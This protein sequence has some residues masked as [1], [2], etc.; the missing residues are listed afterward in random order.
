M[1]FGYFLSPVVISWRIDIFWNRANLILDPRFT[2][3]RAERPKG[4]I[5]KGERKKESRIFNIS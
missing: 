1:S 3:G 2:H 4:E 5:N